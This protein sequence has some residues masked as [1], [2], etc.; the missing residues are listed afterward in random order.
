MDAR[1][2]ELIGEDLNI[3]CSQCDASRGEVGI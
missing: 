1:D 3:H 2:S